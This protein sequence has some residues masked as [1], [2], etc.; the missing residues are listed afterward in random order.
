MN[1]YFI[2]AGVLVEGFLLGAMIYYEKT[3]WK[4]KFK[5][6]LI[7]HILIGFT[8]LLLILIGEGM[9]QHYFG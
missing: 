7:A 2:S 9:K 8:C 5:R 3:S 6:Y 4:K 1:W